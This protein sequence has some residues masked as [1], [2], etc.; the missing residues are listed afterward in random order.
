[1]A[2]LIVMSEISFQDLAQ[3][4]PIKGALKLKGYSIAS[5]IQARTIPVLLEGHDLLACE[6]TKTRWIR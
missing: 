4:D 1:M 3:A 6:K 2:Q 5:P